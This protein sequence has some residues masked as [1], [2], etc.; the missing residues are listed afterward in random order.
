M[1]ATTY[2]AVHVDT[3]G[4]LQPVERELTAPASGTVRI[5]LEANGVCHSD[6]VAVHPHEAGEFDAVPGHEAVGVI[7][8]L[9]EGVTGWAVGDRVGVGFLAGHCGQ[10][11]A[12]RQSDFVGCTDQQWTGV[13]KDGGY[14]EV[15][16]ARQ[17]GLVAIPDELTSE[18]AAPLLC[19][20]FTVYNA[21]LR[22]GAC[23]G[24]LVAIQG[25]G[26]LGHLGIQYA[27]KMGLRVV[28]IARGLA[29]EALSRELGA[30]H[31]IDSSAT[32]VA[33]ELR[34]LGGAN[35]VIAT[36][37]NGSLT[38][39]IGGLARGGKL[40]V[41]G[42]T[43]EP[44]QISTYDLIFRNVEVLG[45]LT[46][47]PAQNEQNLRFAAAQGVRAVSE[48]VPLDKAADAYAR[49]M[50]GDARFRMVLTTA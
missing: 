3:D 45:S 24:D 5:R 16:Y 34:R 50:A 9:G 18:E 42:V 41:V 40:V 10:C 14:A 32:D 27:D 44:I 35:A 17:S 2:R 39:L 19:A 29:K 6:S 15:L 1:T 48:V 12:C 25:I 30:D 8:A 20:G 7:D 38:P 43:D 28:A 49:M 31:Y 47:T 46:G 26:G 37:A 23:P 13:H 22:S 4:K 36:A 11:A 21:L 33:A